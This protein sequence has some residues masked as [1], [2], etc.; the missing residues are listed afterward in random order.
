[1][2]VNVLHTLGLSAMILALAVLTPAVASATYEAIDVSDAGTVTGKVTWKG[3]PPAV[4]PMAINKNPEVCDLAGT[5]TRDSV[6]LQVSASGGVANAVVYLEGIEKGKP[7]DTSELRIDQK[8]CGY[9]PH[10]TVAPR[11]SKITLKSSD[12]ILHNMHM[13]GA[14]NYNIPFP[15]KNA[16]PKTFRKSGVVRLQC[17]AG[18]GWMSAYVHVVDHPYY[19]VT[20]AEGN[21]ELTDVPPGKYTVK[22]WHEHWKV[23]NEITKEGEVVAYEF[24]EPIELDQAA[25][26]TSG[27]VAKVNFALSE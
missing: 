9:S 3:S 7:M 14:A 6:R 16:L 25:E 24:A 13:F 17:D 26:V 18:H 11:K 27:G 8:D 4:A 10:I 19:A 15:D 23:I 20:D 2:R 22:M 5:G 12:E 21:F 1:M